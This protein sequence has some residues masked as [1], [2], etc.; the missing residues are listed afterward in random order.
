LLNCEADGSERLH[1]FGVVGADLAG[2]MTF[3]DHGISDLDLKGMFWYTP[4][5]SPTRGKQ[6]NLEMRFPFFRS[7]LSL[8]PHPVVGESNY[9][10]TRHIL[11]DSHEHVIPGQHEDIIG[12]DLQAM[13]F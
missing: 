10:C 4:Y 6:I 12:I 3:H 11:R 1:W 9:E 5:T 2:H 7:P 8:H 13:I